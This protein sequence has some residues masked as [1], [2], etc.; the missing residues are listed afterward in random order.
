LSTT[1]ALT[2]GGIDTRIDA[3]SDGPGSISMAKLT[4]GGRQDPDIGVIANA[5]EDVIVEQTTIC[6]V[7]ASQ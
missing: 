5:I 7:C 6:P 4:E 3:G 2:P 1:A